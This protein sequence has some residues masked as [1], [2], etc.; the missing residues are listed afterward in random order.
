MWTHFTRHG[1]AIFLSIGRHIC[2]G[3]LSTATLSA[4]SPDDSVAAM[5]TNQRNDMMRE[6]N[7]AH[8]DEVDETLDLSDLRHGDLL[9]CVA[10]T[11]STPVST[12]ITRSTQGFDAL[13]IDHVA[14][15]CQEPDN[16]LHVLESTSPHGVQLVPIHSF[17]ARHRQKTTGKYL[18][19]LGRLKDTA[20]LSASVERAKTYLG[21]PYDFQYLPGDSALYCSELLHYSYFDSAGK[22]IFP[23][24]P[25]SFHDDH[26]VIL[27]FWHDYYRQWNM[28]VPEGQPGTNPGAIS[29]S[30]HINIIGKF[31]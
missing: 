3:V 10:A 23:Q 1:D 18:V 28:P 19:V 12:A 29:R 31:F 21:R 26:G 17:M 20:T 6:E 25:M 8:D 13:R 2:I 27:P 14:I 5:A 30:K 15:V 9:F 7:F 16:Q 4:V 11:K 24:I 22:P